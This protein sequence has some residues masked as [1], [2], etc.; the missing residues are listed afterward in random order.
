MIND[1]HFEIF[2]QLESER[3]IFR[4]F[5]LSDAA[6]IHSV[7]SNEKVMEYMDSNRHLTVQDSENFISKN[8]EL[9]YKKEGIYWAII[10]KSSNQFIGDF[11]FWK[12]NRKDAR[13]ETGYTLKP[14][15]WG[16]GYMTE[17]MIE[18]IKFGFKDLNIHSIEANINPENDNSRKLLNKI[19]FRKEAYFRENYF[20]NGEFLDSEIFSLLEKDFKF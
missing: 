10:E 8:L 19:G 13:A 17:A 18:L 4:K 1:S 11:A 16:K 12:I 5:N 3:L 7:R 20:F 6:D 9:F 15:F 2:P 14:E